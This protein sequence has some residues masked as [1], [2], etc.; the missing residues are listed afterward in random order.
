VAAI[1]RVHRRLHGLEHVERIELKQY[2]VSLCQDI[3]GMLPS[4]GSRSAIRVE[5]GEV[6]VA[7][8]RAVP[9]GLITNELVTNSAKYG[10]GSITVRLEPSSDGLYALA[11]SDE[12]S[13]PPE[14]FDPSRQKGLGM[15]IIS[16]LV[17]QV[18][19]SMQVDR[20]VTSARMMVL[21]APG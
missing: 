9:L 15:K 4:F 8:S 14:D 1:E 6:D 7:K 17:R 13:G 10:K 16:A 11:V 19:G 20:G 18:G 3:A 2:L 21:F 12:G 5:G